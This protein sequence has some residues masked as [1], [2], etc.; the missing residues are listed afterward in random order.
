MPRVAGPMPVFNCERW[1][2][3]EAVDSVLEQ[4]YRD[5][6]LCVIDD[7][8]TDGTVQILETFRDRRLEVHVSGRNLGLVASLQRGAD[9]IVDCELIARQDGDDVSLPRDSQ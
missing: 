5:F 4:T 9:L 7:G 8:S 1:V 3:G 2:F 6:M